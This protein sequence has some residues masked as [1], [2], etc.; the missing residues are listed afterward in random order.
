M[1]QRNPLWHDPEMIL[2]SASPD[3]SRIST[4]VLKYPKMVHGDFMTHRVFSRNASSS[5]AIPTHKLSATTLDEMYIPLFRENKPGMQ[6]GGYLSEQDQA[7]AER[8]W[9]ETAE[10]CLYT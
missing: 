6:P 5:R 2:S 10:H 7:I 9:R 1:I 4:F 3:G 8:L